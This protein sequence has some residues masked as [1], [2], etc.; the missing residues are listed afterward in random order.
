MVLRH[1]GMVLRRQVARP[2]PDWADRAILAALAP[3][4]PAALRGHWTET[5]PHDPPGLRVAQLRPGA[6][7][8][9]P[10]KHGVRGRRGREAR[11]LSEEAAE[12]AR[13][14]VGTGHQRMAS[15]LVH[16]LAGQAEMRARLP[17]FLGVAIPQA[18]ERAGK[19][20]EPPSGPDLARHLAAETQRL[21]EQ[22]PDNPTGT[23]AALYSSAKAAF[24]EHDLIGAI[25]LGRRAHWLFTDRYALG[26]L[27]NVL[28]WPEVMTSL[29]EWLMADD[30]YE[31]ARGPG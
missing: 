7:A 13:S 17:G 29:A 23:I 5:T 28:L 3:L 2:R 14:Q 31:E 4:L 27:D 11:Q 15:L 19:T 12:V 22:A 26:L 30:Q 9:L 25:T 18:Q 8:Q 1:E 21:V 24:A 6:A 10:G 20:D 16:V